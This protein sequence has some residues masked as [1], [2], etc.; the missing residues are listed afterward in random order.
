MHSLHWDFAPSVVLGTAILV[1]A[2]A[3]L[4]GPLRRKFRHNAPVSPFRQAL[5]HLGSLCMFAALVSPLDA[6]ADEYLFSA[7]MA[8]HMLLTFV[9]PPLWVLGMPG[10]LVDGLIPR[11]LLG[12]LAGPFVPFAAFNLVMWFWHLPAIYDMALSSLSLHISEHLVFMAA[13]VMGWLP[14]LSS[15]LPGRMN[16]PTRLAYLGASMLSCTALAALITLSGIQLFT[17]YGNA[18]LQW[19]LSPLADQQLGGLVMWLPGDMLYMVL[20]AWVFATLLAQPGT[21]QKGSRL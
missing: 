9:A 14:V 7:H 15:D 21:E 3:L 20:I 18:P 4:V 6:L 1:F 16:P 13:G 8:Q 19:G 11:R 12:W 2:Y 17:F 5:F 10:W